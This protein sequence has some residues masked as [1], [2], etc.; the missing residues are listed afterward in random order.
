M[1]QFFLSIFSFY[2]FAFVGFLS[3]HDDTVSMLSHFFLN[4]SVSNGILYLAL[5]LVAMHFC[6]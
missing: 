3:L 2:A 1:C 6:R 4:A 5:G